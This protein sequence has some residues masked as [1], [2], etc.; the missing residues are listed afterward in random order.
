MSPVTIVKA[1][2]G[3]SILIEW[4]KFV[5]TSSTF[6]AKYIIWHSILYPWFLMFLSN[7]TMI[8]GVPIC[9]VVAS[10][11][12]PKQPAAHSSLFLPSWPQ[13]LLPGEHRETQMYALHNKLNNHIEKWLWSF[14][15][16]FPSPTKMLKRSWRVTI[17]SSSSGIGTAFAGP[18]RT[19]E[20]F[21]KM[22]KIRRSL[23]QLLSLPW[24]HSLQTPVFLSAQI[25]VQGQIKILTA[26]NKAIPVTFG[27]SVRN[28]LL[29][30]SVHFVDCGKGKTATNTDRYIRTHSIT[31]CLSKPQK[32]AK[33]QE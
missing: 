8:A 17:T 12:G 27:T 23:I 9:H 24:G 16:S 25:Y 20:V 6:F 11:S 4:T 30:S 15:N 22:F 28:N 18:A 21:Q 32:S 33:Y 1:S 31:V 3:P 10:T 13:V 26:Q 5:Q 7:Q 14:L 19:F 29:V 2:T